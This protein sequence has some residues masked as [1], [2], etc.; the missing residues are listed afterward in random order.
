MDVSALKE[1]IYDN[2]R[3]A[4]I[5]E[6]L[7]CKQI[8]RHGD[9]YS[10]QNP[11]GDN[12]QAV[13]VFL[14]SLSVINYT[15]DLDTISAYHDVF[16]LV[17]FY[18]QCDFFDALQYVCDILGLSIYHDF[19]EDLPESIKLT[20]I[21]MQMIYEDDDGESEKPL[22]P[23]PEQVLSYYLPYVNDLFKNDGIS[24]EVQKLFEIGYDP[25]SNRITI[26]IRNYDGKLIGIK[27][28]WFGDIPEGSEIQKYIY[29][30]PCNKG[31]VLYGL[32][33]TYTQ[34]QTSHCVYVGESEKFVMQLYSYG[35]KNCV[36][37]GGKTITGH[38]IE[39]LSRMCADVILCFDKD[40]GLE[41]LQHIGER[42]I[43]SVNVY[44]MMDPYEILNDHESPSDNYDKWVAL[45]ECLVQIRQGVAN[46]Y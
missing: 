6:S 12:P 8:K 24:Y 42:F 45:K 32:D 43:G 36:S 3:V 33:K 26:P 31:Q 13:N 18:R 44:A 38:Q 29:L 23:I 15:R 7:G 16:T 11:D 46:G 25:Y 37:T 20:R 1:Y 30:E 34:I 9:R 2:D 5:L 27:G 19:D 40:V 22:K 10:A 28:R 39:M 4:N 41:E 14:P 17:Q 35:D 21:L